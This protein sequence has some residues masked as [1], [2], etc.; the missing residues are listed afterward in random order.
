MNS[1]VVASAHHLCVPGS[2]F[3]ARPHRYQRNIGT[4]RSF[5]RQEYEEIRYVFEIHT[6]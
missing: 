5:G 3:I 4:G 6:N 1:F 2:S